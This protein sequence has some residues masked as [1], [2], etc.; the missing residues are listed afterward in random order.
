MSEQKVNELLGKVHV[1]RREAVRKLMVGSFALPLVM[2]FAMTGIPLAQA[3]SVSNAT[4]S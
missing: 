3:S 2:S 4:F 1:T